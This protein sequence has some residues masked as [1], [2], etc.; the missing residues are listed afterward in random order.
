MYKNSSNLKKA[1]L[2]LTNNNIKDIS[3]KYNIDEDILL[4]SLSTN[5]S[6]LKKLSIELAIKEYKNTSKFNRNI[7]NIASKYG[8]NGKTLT[9]YLKLN[10][11]QITCNRNSKYVKENAFNEIASEEQAYWLGFM[12]A[13]GFI[14][15]NKPTIG[16]GVSIK[17]YNHLQK[18]NDFLEYEGGMN[19]ATS[20]QFNSKEKFSKNGDLLQMVTTHITN[21]ILWKDLYDKGCVPNKSLIL[22]FP[23]ETLFKNTT[24]IR[25][26]IRGYFD[27]DGTLGVYKHS[28]T[29]SNLEESLSFVGTFNFLKQ[30]QKYIG[31]GFLMK[32]PNCSEQVY[33]LSYSTKK[34]FNVAD[35]LYNNATIYLERKYEIYKTMCRIQSGKNGE[36]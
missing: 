25:H 33:R 23:P 12:Y 15:K 36:G 10:N 4:K 14:S 1:L 8:I 29:N 17:D 9:K 13:D 20:H 5:S 34:A 3:N 7:K 18:F 16:L 31:N 32:K 30:L 24:L 22:T 27:G 19:I 11:I 28:K 2:E 35:Y 21:K 6:E 26:F